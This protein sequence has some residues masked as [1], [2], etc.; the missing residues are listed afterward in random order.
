MESMEVE[1]RQAAVQGREAWGGPGGTMDAAGWISQ[2]P[3]APS[4]GC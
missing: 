1:V 4:A 3:E 2:D